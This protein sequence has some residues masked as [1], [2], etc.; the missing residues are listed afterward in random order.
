LLN[1][2]QVKTVEVPFT[3][4]LD[5]PLANSFVQNLYAPDPDP[6][7]TV[8]V[9]DRTFDQNEELGLNDIKVE[10]YSAEGEQPTIPSTT[11]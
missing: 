1:Y 9:Y 2:T 4:I 11:S 6:N 10:G 5:D 7:M 3:L 8:E